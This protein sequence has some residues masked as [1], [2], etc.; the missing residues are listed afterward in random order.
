MK[1]GNIYNY[2]KLQGLAFD[3]AASHAAAL[4]LE[5][6]TRRRPLWALRTAANGP[7]ALVVAWK[8][9]A[10]REHETQVAL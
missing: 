4:R 5:R 10:G 1:N 7:A 2:G 3:A 8:D 9:K 6:A